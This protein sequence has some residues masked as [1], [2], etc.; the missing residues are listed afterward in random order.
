MTTLSNALLSRE[1]T[2]EYRQAV[3]RALDIPE[4][5]VMTLVDLDLDPEND[6]FVKCTD[7]EKYIDHCSNCKNCT[8]YWESRKNHGQ[9]NIDI[10]KIFQSVYTVVSFKSMRFI[11]Q[12]ARGLVEVIL[13]LVM[14]K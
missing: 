8:K 9:L 5:Q 13:G 14:R 3:T 6:N 12:F 4:C 10:R 7:I 1:P 11:S 2:P